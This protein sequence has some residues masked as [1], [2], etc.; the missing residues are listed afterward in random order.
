MSDPQK[1]QTPS[2]S[3]L[4]CFFVVLA[5]TM[6]SSQASAFQLVVV[7]PGH[8]GVDSGTSWHGILEKTLTLD[9]AKRLETI[10]R[11]NGITTVMTRRY[12]KTI[13]LDDRAI[14]ANRFPN[15]LLVS[16]HFNAIRVAS[17]SGYETFYRSPVSKQIA[18]II[19]KSIKET[20]PGVDRGVTSEDFAVLVRTKGPAVLVECGFISNR[21]EAD[22][23]NTP[24][25]RQLLAEGIAKG[26]LRAKPL[27]GEG[28]NDPLPAAAPP[29]PVPTPA[30]APIPG[31]TPAPTPT[32]SPVVVPAPTTPP[33]PAP[34]PHS[35]PATGPALPLPNQNPSPTPSGPSPFPP[36]VEPSAPAPAAPAASLTPAAAA[37]P[38]P[39]PTPASQ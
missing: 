33:G 19:Q 22:R 11:D 27:I 5:M 30:S 37:A 36:P 39:V 10:L 31:A 38:V 3:W 29:A 32:P 9:V 1:R 8:G 6:T 28:V 7:D 23:C 17:I 25:H 2:G 12:D 4:W 13:S 15:S 18:Q 14:M 26:I 35:I 16:V 24:A 20:V 34:E 21:E